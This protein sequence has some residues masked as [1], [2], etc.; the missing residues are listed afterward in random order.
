MNNNF[1]QMF[2]IN[3]A[4]YIEKD[5][6]MKLVLKGICTPEVEAA[7]GK[8]FHPKMVPMIVKMFT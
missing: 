6:E 7:L 2:K 3:L 5:E 4:K 8:F 1:M